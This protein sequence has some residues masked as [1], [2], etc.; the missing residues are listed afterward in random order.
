M[1]GK[2]RLSM[3]DIIARLTAKAYLE[4]DQAARAHAT[5]RLL[6]EAVATPPK[7]RPGVLNPHTPCTGPLWEAADGLLTARFTKCC[8]GDFLRNRDGQIASC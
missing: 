2:G 5:A 8:A 6:Q 7:H 3:Q 4:Y 1:L